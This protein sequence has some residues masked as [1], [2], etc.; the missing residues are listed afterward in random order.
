ML[1]ELGNLPNT[2]VIGIGGAGG[3]V[4]TR[5]SGMEIPNTHLVYLDSDKH[6]METMGEGVKKIMMS[7]GLVDFYETM[8]SKYPEG[9]HSSLE[10]GKKRIAQELGE[11]K[12]MVSDVDIVFIIA[13]LGKRI[14]TSVSEVVANMCRDSDVLTF[15]IALYPFATE[16]VGIR[17]ANESLERL[18]KSGKV[19][20]LDNNWKA[21]NGK[22]PLLSILKIMNECAA[23][24]ILTI[25]KGVSDPESLEFD[26]S[27]LTS[28]FGEELVFI[29]SEGEGDNIDEAL[30]ASLNDLI[31]IAEPDDVS[32][33]LASVSE[34]YEL[35]VSE[36]RDIIDEVGRRTGADEVKVVGLQE[37]S[38]D[39]RSNIMLMAG[40]SIDAFI[41][42]KCHI[43]VEKD[44]VSE[45]KKPEK[46][47][48]KPREKTSAK[49]HKE[50]SGRNRKKK[51]YPPVNIYAK[52]P[53]ERK[54]YQA[55]KGL[56]RSPLHNTKRERGKQPPIKEVVGDLAQDKGVY[57]DSVNEPIEPEQITDE[58]IAAELTGFPLFKKKG[59]RSLDDFGVNAV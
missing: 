40:M 3:R 18:K 35:E 42:N 59:Q 53:R 32:R 22:T 29:L 7:K 21:Y 34:V 47:I 17:V 20:V 16:K 50:S 48:K 49:V 10:K 56:N 30:D 44:M 4:I 24:V 39:G 31:S 41:G 2:L 25:A 8:S 12:E 19:I 36:I 9:K 54:E 26:V 1:E 11:V 45:E 58:E 27:S 15:I 5:I 13:G 33:V 6:A 37:Y 46:N 51:K 55:L 14:G 57:V 38:N 23:R 52:F 28:F 43:Q